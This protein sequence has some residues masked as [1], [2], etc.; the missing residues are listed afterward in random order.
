MPRRPITAKVI[1]AARRNIAKAHLARFRTR[2][3]RSVGRVRPDRLPIGLRKAIA[4][5][6][7]RR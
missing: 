6:A 2:E 3:P 4:L 5:R 1:R 7:R